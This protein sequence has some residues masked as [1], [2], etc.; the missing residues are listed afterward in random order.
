VN[1]TAVANRR[2][3]KEALARPLVAEHRPDD[4]ILRRVVAL[5]CVDHAL[6]GNNRHVIACDNFSEPRIVVG[7]RVRHERGLERLPQAVESRTHLLRPGDGQESVDGDHPRFGLDEV[8]IYERALGL[9]WEPM[10][11]R[12][13]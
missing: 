1:F 7:M 5:D 11:L 10:N 13:G 2:I 4:L 12:L 6:G 9:R 3:R 8:R